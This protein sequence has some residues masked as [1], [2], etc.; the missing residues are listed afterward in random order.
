MTTTIKKQ[1]EFDTCLKENKYVICD[2][3]TKWCPPCKYIA[4]FLE[5]HAKVNPDIK[6]LK[7]DSEEF[8][9][10]SLDSQIDGL[11]TFILYKN[12]KEVDRL[13][14]GYKD[15]LELLVSNAKN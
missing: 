5:E 15:G 1:S 8:E 14:G 2:F 7:I 13:V 12:G 6:F 4:P 3:Y 9:Q 10:L 11:P